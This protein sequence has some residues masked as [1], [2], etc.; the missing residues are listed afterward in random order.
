[1]AYLQ[2]KRKNAH[3]NTLLAMSKN[4]FIYKYIYIYIYIYIYE[5]RWWDI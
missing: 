5:E 4:M 2:N 3:W 1:M